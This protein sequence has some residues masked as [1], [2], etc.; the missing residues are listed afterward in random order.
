MRKDGR[1]TKRGEIATAFFYRHAAS[2]APLPRLEEVT[3]GNGISHSALD[4]TLKPP[5]GYT[6]PPFPSLYNPTRELS[7]SYDDQGRTNG[8][9][10]LYYSKDIYRFTLYWTLILYV[11]IFAL[12]GLYGFVVHVASKYRNRR[13]RVSGL[14]LLI[15]LVYICA[16]LLFGAIGSAVVGYSLAAVYSVGLFSMSTWVPFLW[17]LVVTLVTIMGSYSTIITIL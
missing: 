14:V 7:S 16:G 13:R 2:P 12:C 9:Y 8:A 3:M 17:S 10:Y 1:L 15:P 11:P 4:N 5:D 6:V